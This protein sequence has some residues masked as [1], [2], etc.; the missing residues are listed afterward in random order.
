[1]RKGINTIIATYKSDIEK[2]EESSFDNFKNVEL[3]IDISRKCLQ[4][5]RF[6]LRDG[7]FI[8][9]ED[10]IK[11]F[12]KQKPYVYGQLKFYTK[13]YKYLLQRPKGTDK[14]K[15]LYIDVE[16]R[17]LQDYFYQNN[18]FIKYYR[19]NLGSLDEFYFL[20]GNDNLGLIA[21]TSHFYTDPEFSTSHDNAV[22]KIMAYDLL[23]IYYTNELDKLKRFSKRRTR[24]SFLE[25][26]NLSWIANKIDLVELIY[27][28]ICS[29]AVKGDIKELAAALEK[30]FNIDSGNFYR[31]F[32][33]IRAR[34]ENPTRFID[35]LKSGLLKR[36]DDIEE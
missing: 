5:L 11:F 21:D 12:K 16:I 1:M 15:R 19:Q 31:T 8:K 35:S 10:E 36:M 22:A 25:N 6:A 13:L 26:L 27:A 29:G 33:E 17:K 3:G 32:L 28:L 34:K 23:L 24:D 9:K 30:I 2:V 18:H 14:S 20:R 7:E 4:K